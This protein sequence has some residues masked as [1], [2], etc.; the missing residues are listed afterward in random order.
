MS[1]Y[2]QAELLRRLLDHLG[3]EKLDAIVGASYGGMVA[4][5]FAERYPA[6]V[7]RLVVVSAADRAHPMATA[8]RSL[9]RRIVR[10]GLDSSRPKAGLELARGLAM[11]TYRSASEFAARFS[12]E[13]R[14]IDGRF[15]FPVEEY[16]M[17]RGE[18]YAR[19]YQPDG[20]LILSESIDL[21]RID[22][23][24]VKVPV[25][26]IAVREDQLVPIADMRALC[27]RLPQA[28]LIEMSSIYGHDAFL[29]ECDKLKALFAPALGLTTDSEVKR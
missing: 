19:R 4:M 9:Q 5:A 3:I 7:S 21:H 18:D 28:E 15:V 25:T 26:A 22:A 20:F 13:P 1:T 27:A 29:K 23:T 16:L 17:A 12:G 6:R 10:L 24:Q 14:E 8:W 11:T 2:D